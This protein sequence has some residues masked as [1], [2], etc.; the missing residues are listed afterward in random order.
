VP[1]PSHRDGGD[2]DGGDEGGGVG[3]RVEEAGGEGALLG[4]EPFGGG[5]DGCGEVA[6]FAEAEQS[7][8][9]HEADDAA[10]ER[11]ADGG[12]CPDEDGESV[13]GLGA[14]FVDDAAGEEEAYAVGDLKGDEDAPV[15]DVVG[16]LVCVIKAGNPAHERQVEERLDEREDRAVHVVDGGG[17]E[18][19]TADGPSNIRFFRGGGGEARVG[20]AGGLDRH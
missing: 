17:E 10:D 4:G 15:V 18:E 8:A 7:A 2:E 1:S 13:A 5:F 12:T 3:A 6:G 16:D 14:E 9:D 20:G 11:G 19:K